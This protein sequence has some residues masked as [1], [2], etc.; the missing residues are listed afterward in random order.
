MFYQKKKKN[1]DFYVFIKKEKKN[2]DFYATWTY[3]KKKGQ[4]GLKRS[5]GTIAIP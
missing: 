1:I 4:F 2:I 5:F 3:P